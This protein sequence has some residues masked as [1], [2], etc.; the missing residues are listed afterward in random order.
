MRSFGKPC[1]WGHY[2]GTQLF[3]KMRYYRPSV[4]LMEIPQ[5]NIRDIEVNVQNFDAK[6]S[7]ELS[8]NYLK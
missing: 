1:C 4:V 5:R 3:G 8:V 2:F 6:Y 7:G